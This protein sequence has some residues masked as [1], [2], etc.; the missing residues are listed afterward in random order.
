MV[1][2]SDLGH[3]ERSEA[4]W[5]VPQIDALVLPEVMPPL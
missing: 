3:M 2:D 1:D 5:N 4:E